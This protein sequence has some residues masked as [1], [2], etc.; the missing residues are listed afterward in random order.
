V[1]LDENISGVDMVRVG[2]SETI[3]IGQQHYSTTTG[4]TWG[5][6]VVASSTVQKL[7]LNCPKST[8]TSSPATKDTYWLI[9]VI[10]GQASGTYNGTNTIAAL[11][12]EA[13]NW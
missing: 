6:G 8:S 4:F 13:Q 10:I 7:E 5:D 1:G 3:A 9:Q 12:G 11:T 2:N